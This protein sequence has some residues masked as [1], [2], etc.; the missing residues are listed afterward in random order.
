MSD[1][2][3][4]G[5]DF[6]DVREYDDGRPIVVM[7]LRPADAD[8]LG[9]AWDELRTAWL[10]LPPH[11]NILDAIDR[12]GR[13]LLVRFAA[14]DWRREPLILGL[15]EADDKLAGAW[16]V[17]LCKVYE[18]LAQ[19]LDERLLFCFVRPMPMVDLDEQVRLGFLPASAFHPVIGRF[20]APE[21]RHAN[22]V[23]NEAALAFLVGRAMSEL[24][25]ASHH[26]ASTLTT[27]IERCLA[28]DPGAR[29]QT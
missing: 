26:C 8:V 28:P 13:S 23:P 19:S 12:S 18:H 20:V 9:A 5:P 24:T 14:L 10:D 7:E 15:G 4:H 3:D 27:V 22:E 25:R 6:V 17:Q 2:R 21:A 16:G 1:W 29:F 11:P